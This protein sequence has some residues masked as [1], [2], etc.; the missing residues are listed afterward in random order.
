VV[1]D[2]ILTRKFQPCRTE[3]ACDPLDSLRRADGA[4][5]PQCRDVVA[6]GLLSRGICCAA[7]ADLDDPAGRKPLAGAT[8]IFQTK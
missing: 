8:P 3:D 6:V 1:P 7:V 5:M 2:Q 4:H